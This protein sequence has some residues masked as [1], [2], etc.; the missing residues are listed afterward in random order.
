MNRPKITKTLSYQSIICQKYLLQFPKQ[1]TAVIST[2]NLLTF[3]QFNEFLN[4][5]MTDLLHLYKGGIY[6]DKY[7]PMFQLY[8]KDDMLS[9]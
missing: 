5:E 4:D 2:T 8:P 7:E 6:S 9:I 3:L 1:N